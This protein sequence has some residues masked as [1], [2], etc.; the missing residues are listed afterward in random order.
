[1]ESVGSTGMSSLFDVISGFS[2]GVTQAT[3][4][5]VREMALRSSNGRLS[6]ENSRLE[7]E[8]RLLE[9]R[10]QALARRNRQLEG[11][12]GRLE[13]EVTGLQ[14]SAASNDPGSEYDHGPGAVDGQSDPGYLL[15]TYA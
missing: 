6:S 12:V 11:E 3:A 9:E 2:S 14:R 1:M 4:P 10:R 13:D 5:S 7:S 15:D 8:N